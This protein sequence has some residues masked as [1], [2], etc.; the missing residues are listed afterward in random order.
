VR[1]T[2]RW[3]LARNDTSFTPGP[4]GPGVPLLLLL[5]TNCVNIYND[6]LSDFQCFN[7]IFNG[8]EN[9]KE[10]ETDEKEKEEKEKATYKGAPYFLLYCRVCSSSIWAHSDTSEILRAI[11]PSQIADCGRPHC[12]IGCTDRRVHCEETAFSSGAHS[13][14]CLMILN[15]LCVIRIHLFAAPRLGEWSCGDFELAE[16]G[17]WKEGLVFSTVSKRIGLLRR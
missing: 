16:I 7:G 4:N 17:S 8:L 6:F 15:H 11:A 10:K 1:C 9:R 3:G 14:A 2:L 5:T 12:C 13:S